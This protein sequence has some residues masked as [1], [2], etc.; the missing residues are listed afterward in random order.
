MAKI[1]TSSFVQNLQSN[2]NLSANLPINNYVQR[3]G[4]QRNL[5]I[6]LLQS[7][8]FQL[9]IFN[10]LKEQD[11]YQAQLIYGTLSN[12]QKKYQFESDIFLCPDLL[13]KTETV[14]PEFCQL[15][16]KN[17][18]EWNNIYLLRQTRKLSQ[19]IAYTWLDNVDDPI[20]K[21]VEFVKQL[22]KL[23]S[24]PVKTF[25]LDQPEEDL[26]EVTRIELDKKLL[27]DEVS[28][29][30][31]DTYLIKP[32]HINYDNIALA[33]LLCGQAF[34][35]ENDQ[36]PTQIWEPIVG[37][38]E[39]LFLYGIDV[40]WDSFHGVIEEIIVIGGKPKFPVNQAT[41][42]YP[43]RPSEF[44]LSQDEIKKWATATDKGG[45]LPFY[46]EKDSDDWKNKK[47]KF[48]YPPVPYIPLTSV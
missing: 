17:V 5:D 19:M 9:L 40:A 4:I 36:Q 13:S 43:P 28:K 16:L 44:N 12:L 33:L 15:D 41:I 10:K 2:L 47:L 48:V 3:T 27:T 30:G 45:L 6:E 24:L 38:Y 34:Y 32:N 23:P 37:I 20:K 26:Q 46:P 21:K 22:F 35:I 8:Y 31:L 29:G 14:D 1:F 25:W 7:Y 39:L 42:P 18:H 11:E